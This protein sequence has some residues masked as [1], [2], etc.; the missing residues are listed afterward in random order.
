MVTL[1]TERIRSKLTGMGLISVSLFLLFFVYVLLFNNIMALVTFIVLLSCSLFII[2]ISTITFIT[3]LKLVIYENIRPLSMQELKV[4]AYKYMKERNRKYPTLIYYCGLDGSGKTTQVSILKNQLSR[5]SLKFKHVWL[6]WVAFTS[7]P[8]LVVCRVLGYTVWKINSRSGTKYVEHHFYRNKAISRLWTLLFTIDMIIYSFLK[9]KIPLRK[10]YIVLMDRYVIDAIID[11]MIETGNYRLYKGF[12]G[13]ILLS[14][15]PTNSTVILIDLDECTAYLRK[16]DI[17][18][19]DY[20]SQRRRLYRYFAKYLKIQIIEGRE[21]CEKVHRSVVEKV[22]LHKPF[23]YYILGA[24]L[25]RNFP[26]ISKS[27]FNLIEI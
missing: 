9:V 21:S 1:S 10:G 5:A 3:G 19:V 25:K 23:W 26:I 27:N 12:F 17:P 6:R 2:L 13:K 16:R 4:I 7:Y 15:V 11:L 8:F 24:Q 18:S 20:L 14:L 22:L